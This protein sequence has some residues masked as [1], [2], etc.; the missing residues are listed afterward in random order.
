MFAAVGEGW[1]EPG[2]D[3]LGVEKGQ[4]QPAVCGRLNIHVP[5]PLLEMGELR[6]RRAL[7][8]SGAAEITEGEDK[9]RGAS[10]SLSCTT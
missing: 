4:L 1:A 10:L 6:A 2:D 7:L 5:S 8:Q 3:P 9:Q